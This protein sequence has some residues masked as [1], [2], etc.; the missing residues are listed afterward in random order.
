MWWTLTKTI[1][2]SWF[3]G[4]ICGAGM[5]IAVQQENRIPPPATASSQT[6]PQTS[7]TAAPPGADTRN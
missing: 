3:V 1:V 5:V 7:G 6:A 4:V 2:I